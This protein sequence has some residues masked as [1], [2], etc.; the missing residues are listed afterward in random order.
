[1]TV[2]LL[3]AIKKFIFSLQCHLNIIYLQ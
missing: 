2:V 3:A 1:M